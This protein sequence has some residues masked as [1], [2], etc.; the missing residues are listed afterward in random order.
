MDEKLLLL[1]PP[2]CK[3]H[4]TAST[5]IPI[6]NSHNFPHVREQITRICRH[7]VFRPLQKRDKFRPTFPPPT[8]HLCVTFIRPADS[9]EG[10]VLAGVTVM[11]RFVP[12]HTGEW[13][14]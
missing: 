9:V 13:A 1:T 7:F 14:T 4:F 5:F 10:T 8:R 3:T 2:A 6:L 11:G 12:R